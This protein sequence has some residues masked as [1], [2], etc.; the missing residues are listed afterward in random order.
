MLEEII[1]IEG[2]FTSQ[3]TSEQ[4]T[5]EGVLYRRNDYKSG[6]TCELS[7]GGSDLENQSFGSRREVERR[8]L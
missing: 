3:F 4:S 6:R 7:M 5:V 1:R 8:L 2:N